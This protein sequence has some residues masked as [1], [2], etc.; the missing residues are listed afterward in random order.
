MPVDTQPLDPAQLP[1]LLC[2]PI[3]RRLTRRSVT[4]WAALSSGSDVTLTVTDAAAGAA[5]GAVTAT[6]TRVGQALWMSVLTLELAEP[7]AFLPGALYDYA[8]TSPGWAVARAPVWDADGLTIG[9]GAGARPLPSFLGLPDGLDAFAI[10]HASCRKPHGGGSDALALLARRFTQPAGPR[11][12]H[13]LLTGDQIYADD[14]AAPLMPRVRRVAQDL[15]GD[16]EIGPLVPSNRIA[17][18]QDASAAIG[19]TSSAASNHLWGYAEFAAMYLL[20]WSDALWPNVLPRF[21]DIVP[22][23]DFLAGAE[24]G[25]QTWTEQRD[26]LIAFRRDLADVKRLLA[27]TPALMIFDDHDVTDDWNLDRPWSET[28][29]ANAAGRRVLANGLL[30]YTLFQH[31]GNAPD[32]FAQ[33]GSP[34]RTIRDA[35]A[36]V[37]ADGQ[38]PVTPAVETALGLPAVPFAAG[39]VDFRLAD[40]PAAIRYDVTLAPA[41]GLP[42]RIVLLDERTMRG[43]PTDTGPCQR[44]STAGLAEMLPPLAAGAPDVPTVIVAAAPVLGF[45]FIEHILQKAAAFVAGAEGPAEFDLESWTAYRPAL[46]AL[47]DRLGP[48]DP[49]VFL[50]GDVHYGFNKRLRLTL[51]VGP[52]R[53]AQLTAS[54]AKNADALT[55]A[56]HVYGDL[57]MRLNVVRSRRFERYE[58]L[59]QAQRQAFVNPPPAPAV[60]PWDD[61]VDIAL[62]RMARRAAEEPAV[63]SHEVA[64]AY[65]LANPQVDYEIR[66]Q[67]H[68]EPFPAAQL[69][70]D[71]VALPRGGWDADRSV[72]VVRALQQVDL[73]R[74]GRVFMGL[75]QAGIVR[76]RTAPDLEVVHELL[77]PVGGDA[78]QVSGETSVT[79]ATPLVAGVI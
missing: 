67:D 47:F 43:F 40:D 56:V 77:M 42:C 31:W 5:V 45:H 69:L 50:S 23:A 74:I 65:G 9:T 71:V 17:D 53:G 61:V 70:Q 75:P 1:V 4:V 14:V 25:E 2:G 39:P 27:N 49:V 20:A 54:S 72:R 36:A 63:F 29:Y 44:V 59:T 68:E 22:A 24:V 19:L 6:P 16:R 55:M 64:Q 21:T 51:P 62:G 26:A 15:V 52:V 60:L 12:H 3:V 33:A 8:L 57:L 10:A 38:S 13:L 79:V 11:L 35:V 76:F 46:E 37:A 18:R 78:T 32:R 66:H 28:I 48:Y 30:A 41:D 73:H 7:A 58:A 34:E